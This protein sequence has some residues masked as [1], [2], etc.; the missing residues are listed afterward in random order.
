M[1]AFQHVTRR[2]PVAKRENENL[3]T[4][5]LWIDKLSCKLV[6]D[7]TV[8][9]DWEDLRNSIL[10]NVTIILKLGRHVTCMTIDYYYL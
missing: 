4:D 2:R 8:F 9:V 7:E 6:C 10:Q 1:R 3:S 5:L